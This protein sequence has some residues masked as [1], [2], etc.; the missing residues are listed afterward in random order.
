MARKRHE[1]ESS[2][3]PFEARQTAAAASEAAAIGGRVRYED[4]D[5]AQRPLT[6]AGEGVAEGFELAEEELIDAAEHSDGPRGP[7]ADAFTPETDG[8]GPVG[9]Y[10]E[11]DQE[12]SS[13]VLDSDR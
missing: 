2:F 13:E 1:T 12:Q 9:E 3:S 8:D 10:G 7:L 5:Q 6:E 11:A 4:Q